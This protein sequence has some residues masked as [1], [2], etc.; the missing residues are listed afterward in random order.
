MTECSD[1]F[2]ACE[3]DEECNEFLDCNSA[4][5]TQDCTVACYSA[6]AD[7]TEADALF[8]CLQIQCGAACT[9][10][11]MGGTGGQGGAAVGAGG[12]GGGP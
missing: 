4:C 12:L 1:E 9:A 5:M 3:G 11:G 10:G 2:E 8:A 6:M 7:T